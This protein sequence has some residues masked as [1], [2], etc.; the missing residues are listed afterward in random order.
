[1]MGK[2]VEESR[3]IAVHQ[4]SYVENW[5]SIELFF[6]MQIPLFQVGYEA[7]T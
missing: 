7:R 6:V 5:D 2:I 1:M 4:Q 3:A